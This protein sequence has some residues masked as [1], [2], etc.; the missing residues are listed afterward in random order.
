MES[1]GNKMKRKEVKP[2]NF[3]SSIRETIVIILFIL[4]F[5]ILEKK[6]AMNELIK[7]ACAEEDHV[8]AFHAF[9]RYQINGTTVTFS[10]FCSI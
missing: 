4:D 9:R 8:S 5:Q 7:V 3:L 6:K 1:K 10:R 2:T